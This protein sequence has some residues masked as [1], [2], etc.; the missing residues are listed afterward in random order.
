MNLINEEPLI[1]YARPCMMAEAA[2]KH[3]HNAVLDNNLN[4]AIEQAYNSIIHCRE[5][6][7]ALRYMRE[8]S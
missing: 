6:L 3:T 1:D 7:I 2:L 4:E 8:K 5:M